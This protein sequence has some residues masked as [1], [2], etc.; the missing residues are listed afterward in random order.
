V[1]AIILAAGYATRLSPLTDNV[2]KPLL[3]VGGRPILDLLL[4][5]IAGVDAVDAVHV[6]TNEKFAPHFTR[7]AA[8]Q[9]AS[10]P[11]HVHNDG[12][13]TNE[14]R[15][16]AMGDIQFTI[17][18]AGLWEKDLLVVA[19]DNLFDFSLADYVAFWKGK[20]DG[21]CIA[22]Y[23][24]PDRDLVR[25][26]SIVELDANDRVTAFVEKPA[27]PTTNLVGIATYL[28][29]RRHVPRVRQYL[30]EGNSPDQPGNFIA[31]LHSRAPVYGYRFTGRWL[32][33]GNHAQLLEADNLMRERLG[34][35]RRSEYRLDSGLP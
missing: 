8:E 25:Q 27:N 7:W 3:P 34:L 26:Y 33:I 19:G 5:K 20:G 16:G 4:E 13:L 21:S 29:H 23:E 28:Y 35:P 30:E 17:E 11:I 22:V 10:L 1:K 12:T 14:T 24:C 18:Q 31:W 2:P 32:D 9:P 15:L 6:V